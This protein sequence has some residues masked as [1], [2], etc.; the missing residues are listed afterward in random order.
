M[1]NRT[2]GNAKRME[3]PFSWSLAPSE[4]EFVRKDTFDAHMHRLT[5][6]EHR[7][8]EMGQDINSLKEDVSEIKS[9]IRVLNERLDHAVDTLTVAINRVDVRIDD[10]S[11]SIDTRLDDMHKAQSHNLALWG[12][13]VAVA[14]PVIQLILQHFWK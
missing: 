9:D 2:L 7:M 1:N 4:S 5:R 8:D 6:M 10:M 3:R 12:L 13:V 14:V 11:K